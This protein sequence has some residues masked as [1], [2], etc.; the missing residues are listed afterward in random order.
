MSRGVSAAM[1]GTGGR[2]VAIKEAIAALQ[3]EIDALEQS[4][5]GLAD[6][7][8][9]IDPVVA[10]I[11]RLRLQ[12]QGEIRS[13]AQCLAMPPVPTPQPT[14]NLSVATVEPTQ[15]IQYLHADLPYDNYKD[16][17][18]VAGK[19][20][21][22]RVYLYQAGHP[23]LPPIGSVSGKLTIVPFIGQIALT[24]EDPISPYN[25]PISAPG[26]GGQFD[27]GSKDYS[28][29]FRIPGDLCHG[30]V[31]TVITVF[32][33]AHPSNQVEAPGP[34]LIFLDTAPLKVRLVRIRYHNAARQL[35]VNAAT[36]SDVMQMS[37]ITL[38]TYP[39]PS[40]QIVRESE[41][42]YTGDFTSYSEIMDILKRLR[43]AEGLPDDVAYIAITPSTP[44]NQT[45]S[46]GFTLGNGGYPVSTV[47]VG[48]GLAMAHELGHQFGR[49]HA[50]CAF[51]L[52]G[53]PGPTD[54]NYPKYLGLPMGSIGEFGFD[55]ID[56]TVFDPANTTDFMSYCCADPQWVSLYGYDLFYSFFRARSGARP[57]T[58]GYGEAR[59]A[60]IELLFLSFRIFRDGR[61]DL[62][63]T[64]FHSQGFSTRMTGLPTPYFVE[65][66]D[67]GGRI[68]EAQ[69]LYMAT[70]HPSLDDAALDFFVGIPWK[71]D[72]SR[73]VFKNE[74]NQI[75]EIPITDGA[76]EV[77]ITSSLGGQTLSGEQR[78][79]W[80]AEG[81]HSAAYLVRYSHDNGVNWVALATSLD[82]AELVVD[83]DRLPGG[84]HC[85]IQVWVS[86][87]VRTFVATSDIFHVPVKSPVPTIAVPQDNDIFV[88]GESVELLGIGCIQ[89][90]E[91][92]PSEALTWTSSMNGL[93]G[94]GTSLAVHRLAIGYHQITLTV[95]DKVGRNSTT[96]IGIHV[97]RSGSQSTV[98]PV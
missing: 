66:H 17:P 1:N 53:N 62:P 18:M 86:N 57:A 68:L 77:T 30:M 82:A 61:I 97:R 84:D 91:S 50:P 28:L 94:R 31:D 25:G 78:I 20:T 47:Q 14:S 24:A 6:D 23:G 60:P 81:E 89:G 13:L 51:A 10:E 46:G 45:G 65:L 39:V 55:I 88:Q 93:L 49:V 98:T 37:R 2:C 70:Y 80:N 54:P 34:R 75:A 38:R 95:A 48:D 92:V 96:S 69:R 52:C 42:L 67:S 90:G 7:G 36:L 19:A 4:L 22:L 33:T 40:L 74:G 5:P 35:D 44:A 56:S 32:D 15:A 58:A 83:F 76:I 8:I 16:V 64:S 79:A 59:N 11:K 71:E 9:K 41:E 72:V 27:R 87:G 43:Q 21:V 26:P 63:S 73:V 12:L 85:I 3:S 29:N